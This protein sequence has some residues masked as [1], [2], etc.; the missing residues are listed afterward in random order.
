MFFPMLI[1]A[2]AVILSSKGANG[3]IIDVAAIG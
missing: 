3:I 1:L 2:V